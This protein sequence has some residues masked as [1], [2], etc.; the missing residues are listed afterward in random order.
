MQIF[1]C[2]V[3][4]VASLIHRDY[5]INMKRTVVNA[6]YMLSKGKDQKNS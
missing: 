3:N 1:E 5:L 6:K 4:I 2:R